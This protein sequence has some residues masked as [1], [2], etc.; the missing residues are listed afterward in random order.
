LFNDYYRRG[1]YEQALESTL[2]INLP[3]FYWH[4]A[5]LAAIYGQLGRMDEAEAAAG[6]LLELYPDFSANGRVELLKWFW[7]EEE[8]LERWVRG[9][10][11]AGL[12][13]PDEPKEDGF[14]KEPAPAEQQN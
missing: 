4:P 10:R 3:G 8:Q 6:K 14:R 9:L 1:E 13:I 5:T 11:K 12:D 2:K 7:N